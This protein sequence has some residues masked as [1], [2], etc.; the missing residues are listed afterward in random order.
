MFIPKTPR[1]HCI[2]CSIV[3]RPRTSSHSSLRPF[4]LLPLPTCRS[5]N[6][7]Q[8]HLTLHAA[9]LHSSFA[10]HRERTI[11]SPFHRRPRRLPTPRAPNRRHRYIHPHRA[12][13]APHTRS[14][15]IIYTNPRPSRSSH[16]T[17][18]HTSSI[19]PDANPTPSRSPTSV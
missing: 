2:L 17:H 19:L 13:N 5:W 14:I 7:H 12:C 9:A 6:Q 8:P 18:T 16:L 1:R 10:P 11:N 15:A 3:Y 4:R